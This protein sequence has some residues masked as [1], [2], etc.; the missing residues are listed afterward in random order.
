MTD[1]RAGE[2]PRSFFRPAGMLPPMKVGDFK[3]YAEKD[4]NS[5]K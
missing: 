3:K 2:I 5:W 4:E 1:S